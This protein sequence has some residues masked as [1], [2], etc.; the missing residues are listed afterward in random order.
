MKDDIHIYLSIVMFRGTPCTW[1]DTDEGNHSGVG[2]LVLTLVI[3]NY[4]FC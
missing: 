4:K 2:H 3:S 1:I